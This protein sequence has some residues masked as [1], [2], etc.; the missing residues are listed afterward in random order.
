DWHLGLGSPC[1]DAGDPCYVAEPNEKDLDGNPRII[2]G[3]IDMG[4]YEFQ[5]MPPVAD[6]GPDQVVECACNTVEGTKVTLDG[7]GSFDTDGDPLTYTWTGPFVESPAQGATPTVTLED[8]CPGGYVITLVVNDGTEDSEPN[9]VMIT[10]ADTT[11]PVIICPADVTLECPA[12]TSVEANGSAAV[13]DTCGSVTIT[14]SDVWQSGCGNTGTLTRTWTATDDCGNSS[15]C[16]QTIT[17]VD[18][19]PPVIT[20]PP[21]VTLECPADTSVEANGSATAGDTCSSATITHS[22]AWQPGCG[23][24]GTLAR[25]WTATDECGNSSTCAQTI[26]VVDTTPPEFE[27]SVTPTVLWPPTHKMVKITPTWTVSDMCDA[28]PGVSLVS[29]SI[30]EINTKG[31]G[32]TEDDIQIGDDGSIYL[33][34]ERSGGGDNR[35]Y[36]ITYRAVD[37][38]GNGAVRSATVTV[39]HDQR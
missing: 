9:D 36:T 14:H 29:I 21:D 27:F 20:C 34:A 24:T 16:V 28:M 18:T 6:A 13:G 12:D 22:D 7:T 17:V 5:N 1:I 37:D 25:T 23:N 30:N 3:R 15:T 32:H 26:T 8:G 31:D 11:P 38:C 19:T 4:A 2:G 33:R 35:V 39:P 10:V